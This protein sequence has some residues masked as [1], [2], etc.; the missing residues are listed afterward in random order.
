MAY[1]EVE[2][3]NAV[4]NPS[5]PKNWP[6]ITININNNPILIK[7]E[8][9]TFLDS[10]ACNFAVNIEETAV[11]IN[12]KIKICNAGTPSEKFGKN[13]SINNGETNTTKTI[14]RLAKIR[15]K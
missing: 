3:K 4:T 11:G 10:I 8:N 13:V 5:K 1:A 2:T 9:P 14:N 15:T 6:K 7:A 12:A